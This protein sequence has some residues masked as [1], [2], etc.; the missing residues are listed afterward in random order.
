MRCNQCLPWCYDFC[1]FWFIFF[2]FL[3]L[4]F[5]VR[6]YTSAV[7]EKNPLQHFC[8]F[9]SIWLRF[10]HM[11]SIYLQG[12]HVFFFVAFH[13]PNCWKNFLLQHYDRCGQCDIALVKIDE[14]IE[15]T[16]TVIDLYSVKVYLLIYPY[17][18]VCESF[19]IRFF[20]LYHL[21]VDFDIW[22]YPCWF[23]SYLSEKCF[24][25]NCT[26]NFQMWWK[27]KAAIGACQNKL[28]VICTINCVFLYNGD[29]E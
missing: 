2:P 13:L 27:V 7:R 10:A 4:S 17:Q 14:A 23:L 15:H 8:G 3:L 25:W 21:F 22:Q 5:D 29:R 16:P 18:N 19:I 24:L 9:C 1:G 28:S 6:I 20:C 26:S 12:F 11:S